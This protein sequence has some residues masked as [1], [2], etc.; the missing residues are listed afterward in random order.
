MST[1][2]WSQ[3][4]QSIAAI[5]VTSGIGFGGIYA[6]WQKNQRSAATTRANVA[7]SNADRAVADASSTVYMLLTNRLSALE[8][9]MVGIRGDLMLERQHSRRLTLRIWELEGLMT[10]AGIIIP[11][12]ADT[13]A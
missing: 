7:E 10:K 5:V 3:V 11:P 1:I 8:K 6:W 12:F 13:H 9:E 4:G 2:D